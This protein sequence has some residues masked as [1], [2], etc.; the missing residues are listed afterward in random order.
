L[1]TRSTVTEALYAAGFNSSGRFYEESARTFG[2]TPTQ[3]K[4]GGPGE[5]IRFAIGECSLGSI[6]VAA[7]E[8][9]V[10][11]VFLG[12]DPGGLARDLQDRFPKASLV[13]GDTRFE[14]L[15]AQVVGLV[16]APGSAVDLPLDVRG[17]VFQ[18]KVWDALRSIPPG[19]T[20]SYS[21]IARRIGHEKSVRAVASACA[22][23]LIAVAIPCHRVVHS[24]GSLSGYRW[25]VDRKRALLLRE[26]RERQVSGS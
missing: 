18:K 26:K 24:D 11:A 17:T 5:T 14:R 1:P 8:K 3:F 23:N 13:G 4:K 25:G 6:L 22:S 9:G 20:A 2:M 7:S 21:E 15:V 10:C 16:E 19:G 12:D